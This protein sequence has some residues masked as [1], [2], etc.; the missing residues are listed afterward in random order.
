MNDEASKEE[1][2]ELIEN[3]KGTCS[4]VKVIYEELRR[5]KTPETELRR[6][7]DTCISLTDFIIR[8]AERQLKEHATGKEEE[9]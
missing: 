2:N 6:K 4:D 9:S 1:L 3:M 8:K 5:L 7:V